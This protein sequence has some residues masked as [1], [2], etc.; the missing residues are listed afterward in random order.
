[1]NNQIKT[2]K[3][4]Y[5]IE[6]FCGMLNHCLAR[7]DDIRPIELESRGLGAQP[8]EGN[9]GSLM[10]RS[11]MQAVLQETLAVGLEASSWS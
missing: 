10:L 8:R 7:Q 5:P 3:Q 2:A 4:G 1:M 6:Q 9:E 11:G